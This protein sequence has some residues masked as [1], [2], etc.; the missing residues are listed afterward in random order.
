MKLFKKSDLNGN[1]TRSKELL[2]NMVANKA[3]Y[4]NLTTTKINGKK[5]L[6][7]Q[8]E[9][10][11]FENNVEEITKEAWERW[12]DRR[13]R[14]EYNLS[15]QEVCRILGERLYEWITN[16]EDLPEYRSYG[17]GVDSEDREVI[18]RSAEYYN[19]TVDDC[20]DWIRE[21]I[22]ERNFRG[23]RAEEVVKRKLEGILSKLGIQAAVKTVNLKSDKAGVDMVVEGH[24]WSVGFQ[25]KRSSY[26]HYGSIES[27]YHK[28]YSRLKNLHYIIY[29]EEMNILNEDEVV[30]EVKKAIGEN[31]FIAKND[32]EGMYVGHVDDVKREEVKMEGTS[33]TYIQW[34]I[35]KE[36]GAENYAMRLFTLKPGG[37]IARHQH[38][39]EHEIYILS[40]TGIIGAGE[41]EV[42]VREGN[43]LYVP[44]DVPHWYVNDGEEDMKFLCIIPMKG[45]K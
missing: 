41:E 32:G 20:V 11:E 34:L 7:L 43:F 6:Y 42:R 18:R 35:S 23:L 31:V 3:G 33:G 36:Q 19:V 21:L 44:P 26:K 5:F 25:V 2:L 15:L 8:G 27:A 16:P 22:V 37:R 12:L 4:R 9:A 10:K 39:W 14:E 40:G 38:P 30:D 13:C 1:I 24:N 28:G 17:R 45:V 29:D